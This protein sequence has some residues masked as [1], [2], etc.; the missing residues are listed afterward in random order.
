M[1]LKGDMMM[2]NTPEARSALYERLMNFEFSAIEDELT[3]EER[4][5]AENLWSDEF[6]ENV[7]IEYKRF[8]FLAA[9]CSHPVTPSVEVDQAWHLHLLYSQSY[10]DDLCVNVLKFPLH[11]M[12]SKGG[13]EEKIKFIKWYTKTLESYEKILSRKPS[14]LIWP[15]VEKRFQLNPPLKKRNRISCYAGRIIALIIIL[16]ASYFVYKSDAG[17]FVTLFYSVIT[18]V[19]VVSIFVGEQCNKCCRLRAVKVLNESISGDKKITHSK[20][21]Y[22]GNLTTSTTSIND[23]TNGCGGGCSGGGCGGGCGG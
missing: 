3:F 12:P 14:A 2:F 11:H 8:L 22:C 10:W 7:I 19:I 16:F 15:P 20:C 9:T 18:W 4:L 17:I 13:E 5:A 23:T 1:I 6:T 21:K